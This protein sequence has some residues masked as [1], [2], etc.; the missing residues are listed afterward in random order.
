LESA[1]A[2]AALTTKDG[3]SEH[4]LYESIVMIPHYEQ[5]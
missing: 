2:F 3:L 4:D 1:F 5:K